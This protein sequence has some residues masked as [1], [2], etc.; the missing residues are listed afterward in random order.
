MLLYRFIWFSLFAVFRVYFRKIYLNNQKTIRK[1]TPY[2]VAS[3]HPNSFLDSVIG[4]TFQWRQW[5]FL[6]RGDVFKKGII[7]QLMT[8]MNMLPIFRRSDAKNN[9]EKNQLTFELVADLLKRKRMVM[10]FSEGH[11]VIEKRLRPITKGTARMA[12]HAC[13]KHGYDIDLEILPT[14]LNYTEPFGIRAEIYYNYGDPIKVKDYQALYLEEPNKAIVTLTAEIEKRLK[15]CIVHVNHGLDEQAEILFKIY[16]NDRLVRRFPIIEKDHVRA[17]DEEKSI[18]NLLNH[19]QESEPKKLEKL[20]DQLF[21]YQKKLAEFNMHDAYFSKIS[22]SKFFQRLYLGLFFPLWAYGFLTNFFV[23]RFAKH[24][25]SKL[26]KSKVFYS[27]LRIGLI[28]IGYWIY[29]LIILLSL[30]ILFSF[31]IAILYL[32]FHVIAGYSFVLAFDIIKELKE[33]RK[34]NSASEAQLSEIQ[35]MRDSIITTV[36]NAL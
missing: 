10:I 17:F 22:S 19:W 11:C 16:K 23:F 31:P 30:S 14:G 1:N 32:V 9:N 26:L 5:N 27:S 25:P 28:I 29:L 3:N 2:I 7:K 33:S 15:V 21:T 35:E 4:P 18:A 20:E 8:W 34:S 13:E 6:A 24:Y 12:F 36:E